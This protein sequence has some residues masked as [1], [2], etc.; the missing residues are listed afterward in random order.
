MADIEKM[1][2]EDAMAELEEIVGNLEK[3]ANK[4]DDAIGAYERGALLKKH[5]EAKLRDAKARIGKIAVGSEGSVTA[6]PIDST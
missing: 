4:L 6:E 2:F 1:S 5:C 3:G